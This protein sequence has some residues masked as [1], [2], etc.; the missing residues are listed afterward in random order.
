[1]VRT[2][3]LDDAGTVHD[4][5]EFRGIGSEVIFAR[6]NQP[7][8]FLRSPGQSDRVRNN[9]AIKIHIR[10]GDRGDV[11]KFHAYLLPDWVTDGNLKRIAAG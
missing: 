10:L 9:A 7:E 4:F 6:K 1:M 2:I 11:G 8:G 5:H 3:Q